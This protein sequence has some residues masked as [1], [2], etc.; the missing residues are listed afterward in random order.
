MTEKNDS[1]VWLRLWLS[2]C[3]DGR[4]ERESGLWDVDGEAW[5]R[6]WAARAVTD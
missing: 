6:Q 4:R 2:K 1:C 3:M 5:P